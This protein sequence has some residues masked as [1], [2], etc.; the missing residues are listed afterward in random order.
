MGNAQNSMWS[1]IQ[2]PMWSIVNRSEA[3]NKIINVTIPQRV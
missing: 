1:S 3:I 2:N